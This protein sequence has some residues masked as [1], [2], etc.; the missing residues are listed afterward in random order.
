MKAIILRSVALAMMC[1]AAST[2]QT[3]T[4]YVRQWQM[5]SGVSWDASDIVAATGTQPSNLAI[6]P[7]G[8]RFDL[9]TI[10][11]SPLTEYLLDSSYVSTYTPIAQIVIDTEDPS[12][13]DMAA[14]GPIPVNLP[15]RLRR[16]RA[17][18]PFTV[19]MNVLGLLNG[20]TDPE[21]SKSVNF[22]RH[23]QSYGTG[24]GVGLNRTLATLRTQSSVTTNGQQTF[25]F[26]MTTIPGSNLKKL[27]GEERFSVFSIAD[28]QAPASQLASQYIQVWPIPD[29]SISGITPN[30]TVRFSMPPLTMV[31]NDIYPGSTVY[32]QVYKGERVAGKVGAVLVGGGK[33]NTGSDPTVETL[34]PT[35]NVDTLFDSD[36]RWTIELMSSSPF[37]TETL[38]T[39]SDNLAFVTF[40]I[41]RTIEVNSTVTT[42]E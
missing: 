36:G 35:R 17:D 7:G 37:G 24:V 8:A 11:S 26:P 15:G 9:W 30:Q 18:R 3:Y 38:R 1:G 29:G 31:Y 19:Y 22:F 23:V 12:G 20:L 27:R 21:A 13:K 10:L 4:N 25:V 28:Y 32:A 34:T 40:T 42:V 14:T 16:T 5:P 6:N 41:D 39:P 2:G 33:T